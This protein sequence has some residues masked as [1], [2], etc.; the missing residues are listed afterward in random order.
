MTK[1]GK[2]RGIVRALGAA[3]IAVCVLALVSVP[4]VRDA[5][6]TRA[7]LTQRVQVDAAGAALFGDGITPIGSPQLMIID[8]PNAAVDLPNSKDGI[9]RVNDAYLQQHHIYPLQLKTV[10]YALHWALI[11][12]VAGIL[13]GALTVFLTRRRLGP[14]GGRSLAR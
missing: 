4:A 2:L 10:D 11:F 3:L 13:V 6:K 5:Y 14:R 9:R 1:S 8:D 7:V 12:L